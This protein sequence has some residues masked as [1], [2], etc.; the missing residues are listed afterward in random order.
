LNATIEA[1][2]AGEAGQGFAVVAR[3]VK[4]LSNQ[5]EQ[6]VEDISLKIDM[7]SGDNLNVVESISGIEKNVGQLTEVTDRIYAQVQNQDAATESISNSSR[8]TSRD[9]QSVTKG[10]AMV[11]EAA[12]HTQKLSDSVH[13]YSKN[14]AASLDRLMQESTGKLRH[15]IHPN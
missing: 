7:M 10:I 3:E 6:A 12:T 5:T 11:S 15:I 2:R 9:M 8:I 4:E 14:L 13:D 1:S